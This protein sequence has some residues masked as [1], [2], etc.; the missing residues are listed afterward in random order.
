MKILKLKEHSQL[1]ILRIYRGNKVKEYKEKSDNLIKQPTKSNHTNQTTIHTN[2]S[3]KI[4]QQT[5]ENNENKVNTG[6]NNKE[7]INN[8]SNINSIDRI[9][10]SE[11]KA[12]VINKKEQPLIQKSKLLS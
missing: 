4:I 1:K 8:E 10:D 5:I 11:H 12:E 9:T 7:N 2:Y 3:P 6:N